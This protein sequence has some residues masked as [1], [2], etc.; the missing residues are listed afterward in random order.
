MTTPDISVIVPTKNSDRTLEACLMSIASSTGIAIELIVIDNHSTD[1]SAEIA[2]TFAETVL[3]SGPERSAQRNLGV[4]VARAEYVAI[5]DS[6][7]VLE[8]GL[9]EDALSVHSADPELAGVVLPERAFGVGFWSQCRVLE[10]ELYLNDPH[11]EACRVFRRDRYLEFGGYDE[12]LVGGEDWE[13]PDRIT[14]S[15]RS[16]GR[17]M[18]STVWHDE[19]QIR[20]IQTFM[21]KRYYGVGV[22][23]YVSSADRELVR[24]RFVRP[25]ILRKWRQLISSPHRTVGLGVLKFFELSGRAVGMLQGRMGRS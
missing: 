5:I 14:A 1:S 21:K 17:A 3:C 6:D 12:S 7:M 11:V 10:K 9:L 15:G 18:R 24:R 13:L 23:S 16:A 19:G 4:R 20:L 25:R 2:R 8:P 22:W